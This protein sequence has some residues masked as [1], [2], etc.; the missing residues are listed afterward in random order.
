MTI[1]QRKITVRF[2]HEPM[3]ADV[4]IGV[5]LLRPQPQN[6]NQLFEL[7]AFNGHCP[8]NH[9]ATLPYRYSRQYTGDNESLPSVRALSPTFRARRAP[10]TKPRPQLI[11]AADIAKIETN[12]VAGGYSWATRQPFYDAVASGVS[13][14]ANPVTRIRHICIEMLRTAKDPTCH[15]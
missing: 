7:V 3:D 13:A 9:R 11:S 10:K 12:V 1:K 6:F 14:S 5:M 15:H 2:N 4:G 8:K